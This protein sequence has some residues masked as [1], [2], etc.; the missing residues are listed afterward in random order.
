MKPAKLLPLIAAYIPMMQFFMFKISGFLSAMYGPVI[1]ES[2]TFLP[3]LALSVSCTATILDDLEL[4]PGRLQWLSDA[5]PGICSFAFYKSMES[6]TSNWIMHVIGKGFFYSRLGLQLQLG[7]LY[8]IV[9]PSKL[10]LF[11]LPAVL[12]TALFNHH[13]PY[14]YATSSLNSTMV[15]DGWSLI[16]RQDSLTGYIS[17]LE[18]A[19]QGFRVMRCDHSLLGGEWLAARTKNGL[20]EPIY[21][22]FVM[23]EAVRLMEVPERVPD[24]EA[25]ALVM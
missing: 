6:I 22:V 21:G 15:K 9:A 12:H 18:S 24:S 17:I 25:T 16:D 3:L 2:L 1:I 5:M 4:N 20:A 8:S 23:L 10:L 13:V 7:A 14:P 11:A 19:K